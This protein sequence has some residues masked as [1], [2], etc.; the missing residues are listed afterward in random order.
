VVAVIEDVI[1]TRYL[2][3]EIELY[4]PLFNEIFV[5]LRL[6]IR[7]TACY[8]FLHRDTISLALVIVSFSF[9]FFLFAREEID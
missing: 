9:P 6:E 8:T 5:K 4:L 3:Y 7:D 2:R 1:I